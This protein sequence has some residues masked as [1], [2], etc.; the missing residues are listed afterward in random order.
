MGVWM[1]VHRLARRRRRAREK[2]GIRFAGAAAGVMRGGVLLGRGGGVRGVR[3]GWWLAGGAVQCGGCSVLVPA[4]PEAV[5]IC[6]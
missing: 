3:G 5:A 1:E 4:G 2:R 6:T